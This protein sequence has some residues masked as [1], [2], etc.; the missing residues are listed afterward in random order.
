M[1]KLTLVKDKIMI[2]FERVTNQETFGTDLRIQLDISH[3]L[4]DD[5]FMY[6][7]LNA[8]SQSKEMIMETIGK[9]YEEYVKNLAKHENDLEYLDEE[10]SQVK[11]SAWREAHINDLIETSQ[12]LI[13]EILDDRDA[14]YTSS[15][16]NLM[17]KIKNIIKLIKSK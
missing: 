16:K 6:M 2:K 14:K 3:E 5:C 10:F 1:K 17:D 7:R 15:C 11:V 8:A 12:T 13:D 9:G 4:V